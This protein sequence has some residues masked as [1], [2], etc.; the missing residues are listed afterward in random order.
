VAALSGAEFHAILQPVAAIGHP[1]IAYLTE[2][3]DETD[4]HMVY[5]LVREIQSRDNLEWIYDYKDASDV[6]EYI[7]LDGCHVNG[8]GNQIIAKR[9]SEML[10]RLESSAT[11]VLTLP[12]P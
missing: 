4:W 2:R 8:L 10:N 9:L 7:Y 11:G 6:D 5:P 1:N 3:G 12:V